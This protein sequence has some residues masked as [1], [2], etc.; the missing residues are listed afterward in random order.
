MTSSRTKRDDIMRLFA[1]LAGALLVY[2][3]SFGPTWS[4]MV[5]APGSKLLKVRIFWTIYQPFPESLRRWSFHVWR[6]VDPEVDIRESQ[7][8][9]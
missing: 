6:V 7:E 9:S 4:I 5:R 8:T 1:A 3:L 2:V